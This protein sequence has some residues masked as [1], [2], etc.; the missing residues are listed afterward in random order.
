MDQLVASLLKAG[1]IGVFAAVVIV[2]VVVGVYLRQKG[3]GSNNGDPH[4]S[5]DEQLSTIKDQLGSIGSRLSEVE[6]DLK[7]RP[8]KN[9][10]HKLE[11]VVVK[12]N[13]QLLNIDKNV[14]ATNEAVTSINDF[15]REA[16]LRLKGDK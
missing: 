4:S 7:N 6:N 8:T 3:I 5:T 10:V 1:P 12:M 11:L 9:E 16:A 13:E 2:M 14:T 15:M